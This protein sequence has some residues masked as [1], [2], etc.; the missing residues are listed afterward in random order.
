MTYHF[1][2]VQKLVHIGKM[3]D[4]FDENFAR[5]M[6]SDNLSDMAVRKICNF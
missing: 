2:A 4:T 3:Y 1:F 6:N 5:H